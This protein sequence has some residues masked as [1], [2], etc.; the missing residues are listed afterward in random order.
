MML[1][2]FD[3]DGTL[4]RLD[5]LLLLA[6]QL[7]SREQYLYLSLRF[8]PTWLLHRLRLL[9]ADLAKERFLALF[10]TPHSHLDSWAQEPFRESLLSCLRP[11]ALAR[12]RWH[13]QQGHRVILCSASPR[14][15]LQPLADALSVE[16]LATELHRR[17]DRWLP[18]LASPNCKGPEKVRRLEAYVVNLD[19]IRIEAYGDSEGDRDL[20][21]RADI[22]HYRS[23]GPE[24]RAYPISAGLNILLPILAIAL[25]GYGLAGI[26]SQGAALGPLLVKTSGSI[27]MG[28]FLVLLGYAIR[29]GRWRLLMKR[30]GQHPPP[31][32]DARIWMASYAFTATPGKAGEAVRSLL[33]KQHCATPVAPSLAAL[34]V[35]RLTDGLAVLLLLLLNFSQWT[36]GQQVQLLPLVLMSLTG[37]LL[38]LYKCRQILLPR[39]K[40]LLSRLLP[41]SAQEGS[42]CLVHLLSP[43]P[44]LQA[45][46][47]GVI[48]WSME[49][50]SL[51]LLLKALGQSGMSWGGTIIAHT[52]AGLAGALSLLPG[53]LGSTEAGTVGL[54]ALQGVPLSIATPA[55]LLIRLMTLWFAT[56]L[57]LICMLLPWRQKIIYSQLRRDSNSPVSTKI[58]D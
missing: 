9:S 17:G 27:G 38:L 29:F 49:G 16:L 45:T 57:G 14:F 40:P 35:E 37:G 5:S 55:T 48:A 18:K 15:Y 6:R 10:I 23:F 21:Q 20:L 53:G 44:L 46:V 3:V 54:L 4:L 24:P 25:V 36:R 28:L 51:G 22:P 39:L 41:Q 11:E 47:L 32:L 2:V 13:Q 42:H 30:L 33:L 8:F 1:A 50:I 12:L 52:A 56:G 7:N 43:R 31:L 19:E 58:T 26:W 34:L